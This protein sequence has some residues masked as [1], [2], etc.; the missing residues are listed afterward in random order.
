MGAGTYPER[1]GKVV[2]IS[3][4]AKSFPGSIAFR[5][6]QRQAIISDPNWKGGDYYDGELPAAGLQLA[7]QIGT[8][9]YRSGQ[10]WQQRFSQ[11]RKN[12]SLF[13][14]RQGMDHEFLIE[15]YLSHQ[16]TKWV[17]NYDPNSM[18]WISKA[19]DGFSMEKPNKDGVPCLVEGLKTAN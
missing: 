7:R 8:I 10:E 1:V 15:H 19:M 3:A 2:S 14:E 5:H 6:A 4:C 13:P 17:N 9:T 11:R 12:G 18:L 16:G